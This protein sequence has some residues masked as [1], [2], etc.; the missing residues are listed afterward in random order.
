MNHAALNVGPA[1]ICDVQRGYLSERLSH[2]AGK[3]DV[4]SRGRFKQT[5]HQMRRGKR[6][7]VDN[8]AVPVRVFKPPEMGALVVK[9]D[10]HIHRGGGQR[11]FSGQ[12]EHELLLFYQCGRTVIQIGHH[13]IQFNRL[14]AVFRRDFFIQIDVTGQPSVLRFAEF[15]QCVSRI[16]CREQFSVY[17]HVLNAHGDLGIL[18]L[19]QC[20][21]ELA[22]SVDQLVIA[23]GY[24]GEAE[25]GA[26]V[27]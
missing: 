14:A 16:V 7:F 25:A 27:G 3:V 1:E 26:M 11:A 8:L 22:A 23:H 12:V 21:R 6:L 18:R 20:L 24:R 13:Q 15:E 4:R 17:D 10:L 9:H 19:R 5:A 2:N